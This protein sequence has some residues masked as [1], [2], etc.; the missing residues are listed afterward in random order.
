MADWTNDCIDCCFL[1]SSAL[2]SSGSLLEHRWIGHQCSGLFVGFEIDSEG[3]CWNLLSYSSEVRLHWIGCFHFS[4]GLVLLSHLYL[5]QLDHF[6][7]LQHFDKFIDSWFSK[8]FDYCICYS[9]HQSLPCCRSWCFHLVL[10]LS[11]GLRPRPADLPGT[12]TASFGW[13]HHHWGL[14]MHHLSAVAIKWE[15]WGSKSAKHSFVLWP[16]VT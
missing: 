10:Q 7:I 15:F 11:P 12:A 5:L 6:Q 1:G 8:C 13:Q 3:G 9:T 2:P 4:F 16:I 14:L